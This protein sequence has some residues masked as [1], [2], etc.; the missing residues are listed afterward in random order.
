[1]FKKALL[2]ILLI[3]FLSCILWRYL[4]TVDKEYPSMRIDNGH[5]FVNSEI[6]NWQD[7]LRSKASN[8]YH[9]ICR[10][11]QPLIGIHEA[12]RG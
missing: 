3:I 2:S 5:D 8:G 7:F 10:G 9:S 6:I 12:G 11:A 4:P 1:M